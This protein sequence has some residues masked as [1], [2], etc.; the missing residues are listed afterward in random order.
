MRQQDTLFHRETL[1]VISTHN[2]DN[3]TLE[4]ITKSISLDF[5]RHAFVVKDSELSLVIDF[6]HFLSTS[7]WV[8]QV[9]LQGKRWEE[10]SKPFR[11]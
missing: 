3:I 9:E 8:S 2:L 10:I 11:D 7:N 5:L 6:H 1:L 4:F